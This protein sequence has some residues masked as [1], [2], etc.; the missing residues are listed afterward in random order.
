MMFA[1]QVSITSGQA[2]SVSLRPSSAGADFSIRLEI[3]TTGLRIYDVAATSYVALETPFATNQANGV[4]F[5]ICIDAPNGYGVGAVGRVRCRVR[6]GGVAGPNPDRQWTVVTGSDS[7]FRSTVGTSLTEWGQTTVAAGVAVWRWVGAC[8]GNTVAGRNGLADPTRGRVVPDVSSPVHIEDG[9]RLAMVNGPALIGQT[10]THSTSHDYPVDAL[11]VTVAPSPAQGWRA[12]GETQQDIVITCDAGF[13]AGDLVAIYLAGANFPTCTL[14]QD[15]GLVRIADCDL[16][17]PGLAF[18]RTRDMLYSAR[19]GTAGP[20]FFTE[21]M[22]NGCTFDL[23]SGVIRRIAQTREGLWTNV[24]SGTFPHAHLMIED[25]DGADPASGTGVLRMAS[26]LFLATI[27][28]STNR[29]TL[30]IPAAT[31]ADGYLKLGTLMIG[32]ACALARQY[33]WGRADEVESSVALRTLRGGA[34]RATQLAPPRRAVE[35][36]WSSGA[37]LTGL[38]SA[39]AP[40]YVSI[41]TGGEA[42]G[43]VP[44]TLPLVAGLLSDLGG[45]STPGLL[46]MRVPTQGSAPTGVAPIRV[47]DPTMLVFGRVMTETWRRDNVMG[48]EGTDYGEIQRGGV[49]RVEAEQ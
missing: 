16:T 5:I 27:L 13:R 39:T 38:Y 3:S 12:T 46:C 36:D 34:R 35:I 45:S 8:A 41:S 18:N 37:D 2:A 25:Y 21:G 20:F 28:T 17:F 47:L 43:S 10:W 15:A 42:H 40:D 44:S 32:R 23:G 1:G 31:T 4:A 24:A 33:G 26:G 30:R 9:L 14:Y 7:L 49:L 19:S 48:E 11:D 29:L 22:L 6:A